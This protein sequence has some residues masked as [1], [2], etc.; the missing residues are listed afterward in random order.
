MS[1]TLFADFAAREGK[2][3]RSARIE[4]TTSELIP[5]STCKQIKP[6]CL[7]VSSMSCQNILHVLK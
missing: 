5:L 1:F 6:I 7:K 2:F 3:A 4:Q